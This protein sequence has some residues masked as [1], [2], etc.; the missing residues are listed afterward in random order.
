MR[1][2][3]ELK[4]LL[5]TQEQADAALTEACRALLGE[6]G[7]AKECNSRQREVSSL[8]LENDLKLAKSLVEQEK[9]TDSAKD[10]AGDARKILGADEAASTPVCLRRVPDDDKGRRS[11]G[12]VASGRESMLRELFAAFLAISKSS[13]FAR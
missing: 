11:H 13:S 7:P 12:T 8:P 2:V 4:P 5:L 9:A 10:R 6:T 1:K 3:R